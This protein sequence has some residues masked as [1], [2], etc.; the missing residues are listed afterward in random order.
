MGKTFPGT[1]KVN[2][3]I[4]GANYKTLSL[5]AVLFIDRATITG[6][7]FK[8]YSAAY[9][10]LPHG[11]QID[12]TL[13]DG[14]SVKYTLD[15]ESGIIF[16]NATEI[17]VYNVVATITGAYYK[18]LSLNATI[19]ITAGRLTTVTGIVL[20]RSGENNIE[21]GGKKGVILSWNPVPHAV[22]YDVYVSHTNGTN[23][24]KFNVTGSNCDIKDKIF[25][26]LCRDKYNIQIMAIPVSGDQSYAPSLLSQPILY[27]HTGR[28]YP[29]KN[30]KITEGK[31]TWDKVADAELYEIML[32]LLDNNG[33]IIQTWKGVRSDS[34]SE[35]VT[36]ILKSYDS[37][38]LPA[39]TY[40][41]QIRAATMH[42]SFWVD[43]YMSDFSSPSTDTIIIS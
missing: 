23:L 5:T 16:E 4:E 22:S 24:M 41:F 33:A 2:A 15:T 21:N 27:E 35:L 37:H 17:G 39:G 6:I 32:C 38:N 26:T 18:K 43:T 20:D 1:Y 8:G 25:T 3:V 13:P 14:V 11:I 28:L 7:T 30:V 9:D 10:A 12:G 29:P 31:L 36:E 34:N 42:N 19:I 40:C